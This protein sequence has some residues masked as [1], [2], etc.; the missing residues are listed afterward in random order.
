MRM[1]LITALLT[2]S[3][4][5]ARAH[6]Q[7]SIVGAGTHTCAQFGKDYQADPEGEEVSYFTWAQGLMSGYNA[8]ASI[9]DLPQVNTSAMSIKE[10]LAHIRLYCNEHPLAF[11]VTAVD[12]L[13]EAMMPA[14]AHNR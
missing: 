12:D 8:I 4:T 3:W 14:I 1:M 6:D 7:A 13:M 2:L 11:Y 5:M 9:N 10:Q